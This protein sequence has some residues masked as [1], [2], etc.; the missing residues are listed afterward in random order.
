MA[1][2]YD[3]MTSDKVYKR[4]VPPNDALEYIMANSGNKFDYK[5]V[6][7]FVKS[8][9][10]YPEGT[11]VK[12]SNGEIGLVVKIYQDLTFRPDVKI[13]YSEDSS[14][15]NETI[16]LVEQNSIVIQGIAKDVPEKEINC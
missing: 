2:V 11:I 7:A 13:I 8:V 14:R 16:K 5:V 1:D 9:I 3:A 10:P 15:I 6:Q 4:A 12:L